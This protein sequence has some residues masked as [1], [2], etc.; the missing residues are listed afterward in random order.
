MQ[1]YVQYAP[2][3]HVVEM[4]N[5]AFAEEDAGAAELTESRELPTCTP[6]QGGDQPSRPPAGRSARRVP[7]AG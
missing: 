2:S 3:A 5:A 7:P 1:I 6:V 4:V